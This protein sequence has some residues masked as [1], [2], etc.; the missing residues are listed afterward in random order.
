M[1]SWLKWRGIARKLRSAQLRIGTIGDDV[2]AVFR[3]TTSCVRAIRSRS[4]FR[5]EHVHILRSCFLRIFVIFLNNHCHCIVPT[6]GNCDYKACDT[7]TG[8]EDFL[9]T[10]TERD[11]ISDTVQV[12]EAAD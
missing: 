11:E 2:I 4:G 6:G 10:S 3:L 1:E 7:A 5:T 9:R 12:V 8:T